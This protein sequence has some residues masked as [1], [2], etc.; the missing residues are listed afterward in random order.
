MWMFQPSWPVIFFFCPASSSWN[1]P[2]LFRRWSL[3]P[4]RS[5]W[6]AGA[7]GGKSRGSN[8][9]S[10]LLHFQSRTLLTSSHFAFF[11]VFHFDGCKKRRKKKVGR[12]MLS[13]ASVAYSWGSAYVAV[14]QIETEEVF[15]CEDVAKN[16][17]CNRK[18]QLL[19]KKSLR[20]TD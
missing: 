15:P 18:W 12:Q 10:L 8:F 13:V 5:P 9:N 20:L 14:K 11:L 19:R 16:N 7:G 2:V 17:I 4:P 3:I 6:F 1:H